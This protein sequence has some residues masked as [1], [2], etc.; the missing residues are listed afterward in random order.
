MHDLDHAGEARGFTGEDKAKNSVC[1]LFAILVICGAT[2]S[3]GA[4]CVDCR[5][6]F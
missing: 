6:V 3:T 4:S 5:A 1:F 2:F